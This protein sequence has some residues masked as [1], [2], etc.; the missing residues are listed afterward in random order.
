MTHSVAFDFK[1]SRRVGW[2]GE[3]ISD[4]QRHFK[5]VCDRIAASPVVD[6]VEVH[7]DLEDASLVLKLTVRD[8]S[9]VKAEAIARL[10]LG[11]AIRES[12]AEHVGLLSVAEEFH[13]RPVVNA[14]AG[15]R[16]PKWRHRGFTPGQPLAEV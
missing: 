6:R 14:W 16:T 4:L 1:L 15:L 13:C 12:G 7:V 8:D 11:R 10:E 3:G 5:S 9:N 2:G